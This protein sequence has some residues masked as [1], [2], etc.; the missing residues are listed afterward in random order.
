MNAHRRARRLA[1]RVMMAVLVGSGL[2]VYHCGRLHPDPDIDSIE[3][4]GLR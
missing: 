3:S 4:E 1:Y 2:L